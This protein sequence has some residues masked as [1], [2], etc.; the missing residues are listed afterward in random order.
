MSG[1]D[2]ISDLPDALLTH[3]LSYRPT[4]EVVR[5]CL[6]SKRWRKVWA[7]VPVLDFD[8]ADF[9]S[10]DN[11]SPGKNITVQ[12]ECHNNFVQFVDAVL[13]QAQH[14]DRFRL[15][16]Q[17]Q[18]NYHWYCNLPVKRWIL[19]VLQKGPRVLS[20]YIQSR[21][22]SV[23]VPDLAFTCSSLEEMK[24]RIDNITGGN[25][26]SLVIAGCYYESAELQVSASSLQYLE[27]AVMSYSETNILNGLLGVT[28]LDVVL[29]GSR[30]EDMLK[31]ALK[32]CPFFENLKAAHFESF[33]GYLYGC[34]EMIDHF[35]QH[36]PILEDLTFHCYEDKSD[37]IELLMELR[38]VVGDHRNC[39]SVE[40]MQ[41]H[42]YGSLDELE[43]LPLEYWKIFVNNPWE[44]EEDDEED[45]EED[46]QLEENVGGGEAGE[47]VEA[48]L[49]E[50]GKQD[51]EQ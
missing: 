44:F 18:D 1:T 28:N 21:A 31:H 40:S 30:A 23:D 36:A 17:C 26:K 41:G 42:S 48:D 6:L 33:E 43:E 49:E 9:Y 7:S 12:T 4:K 25:L 11:C 10:D 27:V 46:E 8:F 50:E 35:V 32:N 5:T 3:I 47:D 24:L 34:I 19:L 22:A 51:V 13:R 38:K 37:E 39:R 14:L 2:R 16:W 45:E 15:V 20:I 29:Y